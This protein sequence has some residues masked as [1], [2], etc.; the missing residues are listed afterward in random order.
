VTIRR[1]ARRPDRYTRVD[2]ATVEDPRLSFKALGLLVYLLSKPDH[3]TVSREHL[4]TTHQDGETSIRTALAEL[5]ECGYL[6]TE[7]LRDSSGRITG[8]GSVIHERPQLDGPP[9]GGDTPRRETIQEVSAPL[10]STEGATTDGA[11]PPLPPGAQ[12]ELVPTPPPAVK[13]EDPGFAAFWAIY[14][15]REG[16]GDARK[17]WRQVRRQGVAVDVILAGARRYAAQRQGEDPQYTKTPGPWLRA[18]RWA[19]EP[20]PAH[21]P[22]ASTP[23][24]RTMDRLRQVASGEVTAPRTPTQLE[25]IQRQLAAGGGS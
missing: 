17:A 6:T 18:E 15:R 24:G 9:T 2:N 7:E 8:R 25:R 13:E 21:R 3:W 4:A 14:P 20:A 10:V 1:E 12:L 16:K 22:A 19:D 5:R 11:T 23:M